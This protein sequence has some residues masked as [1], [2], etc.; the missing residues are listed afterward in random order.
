M[1]H[2]AVNVKGVYTTKNVQCLEEKP[3]VRYL[4]LYMK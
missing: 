4:I 2:L 1:K 3:I